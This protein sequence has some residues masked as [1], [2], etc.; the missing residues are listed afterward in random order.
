MKSLP[1]GGLLHLRDQTRLKHPGWR[2]IGG[3]TD[4]AHNQPQLQALVNKATCLFRKIQTAMCCARMT[5][6]LH[7]IKLAPHQVVPVVKLLL[8]KRMPDG[9][10]VIFTWRRQDDNSV[11][12]PG[13]KLKR[14]ESIIKGLARE[15][16]EECDFPRSLSKA[17]YS[18]LSSFFRNS[19]WDTQ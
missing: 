18:R 12:F 19:L 10:P 11:D 3:L 1:T 5:N 14:G 8:V 2:T 6:I 17:L 15:L 9:T 13:G 16:T 4:H 7:A